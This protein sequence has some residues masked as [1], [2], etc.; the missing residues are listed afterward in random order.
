MAYLLRLLLLLIS[1][2]LLPILRLLLL[3]LHFSIVRQSV[4][5]RAN[6]ALVCRLFPPP[7][8]FSLLFVCSLYLTAEVACVCVCSAQTKLGLR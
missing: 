7:P 3:Q 6:S 1:L 5:R 2:L 4:S 8:L